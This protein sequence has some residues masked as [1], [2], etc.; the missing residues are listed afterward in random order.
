MPH[1]RLYT[2]AAVLTALSA[3]QQHSA[4]APP[5]PPVQVETV[6]QA[7][8]VVV[9]ANGTPS[10]GLVTSSNSTP[11]EAFTT[12]VSGRQAI[13]S[14]KT[15][16]RTAELRFRT[17]NALQT[18]LAIEA[19]VARQGG[20]VLQNHLG[21]STT[22]RTVRPVSADSSLEITHLE[23]QNSIVVRVPW[24]KLDTTLRAIGRWAE[25]LDYRRVNARD[26]GL[27]HLANELTRLRNQQVASDPGGQQPAARQLALQAQTAADEA[28]LNN[29]RLADEVRY[30]TVQIDIY[31]RP[32]VQY[33]HLPRERA[34][35]VYQASL[36]E[37]MQRGLV[38]GWQ[39]LRGLV[40]ALVYA[41]PLLLAVGL[42][43][44]WRWYG[45]RN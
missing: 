5:P 31:Q 2:L 15:F 12:A 27:D 22:S 18:T 20:F 42:W 9:S 1:L 25:F 35:P 21:T 34:V 29:L 37:Q 26:V 40:L 6:P 33:A 16:V 19:E 3:C 14:A 11:Q 32:T 17:A 10:G 36:G 45:K 39:M 43:L 8:D 38:F 30:S 4:E 23:V 13:D 24:Q 7:A 44:G 41:W 28:R